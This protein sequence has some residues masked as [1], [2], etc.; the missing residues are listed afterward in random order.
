MPQLMV[1]LMLLMALLVVLMLPMLLL[2]AFYL[3]SRTRG[4]S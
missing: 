1:L 3:N 2:S 4:V